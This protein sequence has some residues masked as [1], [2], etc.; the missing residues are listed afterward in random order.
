MTAHPQTQAFEDSEL[1]APAP[2][3]E[4]LHEL[5][6]TMAETRPL[7]TVLDRGD[8]TVGFYDLERWASRI[9]NFLIGY[10]IEAGDV[11]AIHQERSVD[12]FMSVLGVLKAGG[13]YVVVDPALSASAAADL[14]ASS[15]AKL[16]LG[17]AKLPPLDDVVDVRIILVE[18]QHRTFDIFPGQVSSIA[19]HPTPEQPSSLMRKGGKLVSISHEEAVSHAK[20]LVEVYGIDSTDRCYHDPSTPFAQVVAEQLALLAAG[21]TIVLGKPKSDS[22]KDCAAFATA[23]RITFL[24]WGMPEPSTEA[25]IVSM[26]SAVTTPDVRKLLLQA[27]RQ[28]GAITR[29]AA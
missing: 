28:G 2:Q 13:T 22:P 14:I 25:K 21:A 20:S 24:G 8:E 23:N 9:A 11:V 19:A 27:G 1:L 5:I 26:P 10:D 16:V 6:S 15:G 3:P 12:L 17:S 7:L 29:F 18:G 4:L